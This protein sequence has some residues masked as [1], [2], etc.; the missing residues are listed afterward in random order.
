M[1]QL[2]FDPTS[3]R[4]VIIAKE[5]CKPSLYLGQTAPQ[6]S[7]TACPFCP[8]NEPM[9][10]HEIYRV[11][12]SNPD[13]SWRCRVVPN[14]YPVLR[15]EEQLTRQA[16]GIFDTISGVGAHEVIIDTPDHDLTLAQYPPHVWADL[17]SVFRARIT[18]LKND[19]R[20]HYVAL[21]KT[22]GHAAGALLDH[23]HSQLIALPQI[24]TKI[25]EIWQT[26]TR[27]Y[28]Q[29][30]RCVYCDL[31]DQESADQSR[32]VYENQAFVAICP[33]VS[34]VPFE[35]R[36]YPKTH[37]ADFCLMDDR[38]QL[39]LADITH[40]VFTRLF[41]ALEHPAIHLSIQTGPL[42]KDPVTLMEWGQWVDHAFHWHMVIRPKIS[43]ASGLELDTGMFIN[44]V[45]PEDA[46][47]FLRRIK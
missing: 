28:I 6:S 14:K 39:D 12:A 10:P 30:Q 3:Q 40:Q 33:Y 13:G 2:R 31:I 44:T 45:A 25:K 18:D 24:P 35:I 29:K 27:Y 26:V 11:P 41:Q 34:L 46:A 32:L 15:V 19:I 5:R 38:Q 21:F 8:G 7:Q 20:L 16:N 36:I 9:A 23:P 42:A 43:V 22:A 1:S 47:A 17:F 37:G 4:W